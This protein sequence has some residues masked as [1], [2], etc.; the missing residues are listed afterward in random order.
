M[1]LNDFNIG[2]LIHKVQKQ[3]TLPFHAGQQHMTHL[4]QVLQVNNQYFGYVH[5]TFF[6]SKIKTKTS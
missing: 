5:L 6:C 4:V 3:T 2:V 1:L